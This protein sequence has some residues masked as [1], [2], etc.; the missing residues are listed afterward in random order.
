MKDLK[1]VFFF[2]LS[3]MPSRNTIS[4][5]AGVFEAIIVESYYHIAAVLFEKKKKKKKKN[6]EKIQ[7]R[8]SETLYV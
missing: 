1:A 7:G 3:R 6:E 8:K 4:S 2:V 5:R